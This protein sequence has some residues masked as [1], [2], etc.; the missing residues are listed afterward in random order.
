VRCC[1]SD[2]ST[3]TCQQRKARRDAGF[4]IQ[5]ASS[6]RAE[7][8]LAQKRPLNVTMR[9]RAPVEAALSGVGELRP[10][11]G[12]GTTENA[13][14]QKPLPREFSGGWQ[15]KAEAHNSAKRTER[16]GAFRR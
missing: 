16:S 8:R 10:S 5:P 13:V 2:A 6:T 4:G 9:E 12:D 3:G 11:G 15:T 14:A 7:H 1:G